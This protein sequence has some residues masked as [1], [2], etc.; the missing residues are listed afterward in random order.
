MERLVASIVPHTQDALF[1]GVTAQLHPELRQTIDRLL[2]C[3]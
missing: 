1:E 3:P 2:I